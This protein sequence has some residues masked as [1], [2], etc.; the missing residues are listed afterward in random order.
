MAEQGYNAKIIFGSEVLMDLTEDTVDAN[1]LLD[2][3]TAHNASG[4]PITGECTYDADTSDATATE[5]E[6][7]S[8]ATYYKDGSKYEGTMTNNGSVAIRLDDLNGKTIPVGFHDGSGTVDIDSVEKGK[9]IPSNIKKGVTVLGVEGTLDGSSP[10]NV[11]SKTVTPQ[12]TQ[13]TVLPD[14]GYDYLSQVTVD[15][16]PYDRTL[17]PTSGGYIVTIAIPQG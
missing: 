14:A 4:E 1:S 7:L 17:D 3:V 10:V 2:G 13:Q 15:A 5:S 11:Q 9:I 12:V 8:G 6:V 16:I